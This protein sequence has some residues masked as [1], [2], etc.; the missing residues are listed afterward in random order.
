VKLFTKFEKDL[1]I[2]GMSEVLDTIRLWKREQ[3]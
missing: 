1:D 2:P 3:K